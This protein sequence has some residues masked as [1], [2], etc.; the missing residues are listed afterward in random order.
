MKLE[1]MFFEYE[2]ICATGEKFT[3]SRNIKISSESDK[4][5]CEYAK[6]VVSQL[7]ENGKAITLNLILSIPDRIKSKLGSIYS[8][9]PESY[10]V[11]ITKDSINLYSSTERGLI[12][13]VST[14]KHL[15]E[16]GE[17]QEMLLYDYPDKEVR[18]YRVYTPGRKSFDAFKKVI[19]MLVEYKYNAVMLEV[20]GAMEYKRH[21]EINKKWEAFCSEVNKSPYEA[22]RIQKKTYPGWQKNSIHADNGGG[23]YITQDEMR[24]LIAYCR[25]REL[26]VIP[27]VP[28]LSH[29][30]YIVMTYPE[31]NE[32]AEDKYP[33][34]YCPSNP[35]SYEIV[36]DILDEV[37][38]VFNPQYVNIG[39]DECYTLAKCPKCRDKDP[40]DLY[41]GDIV[42]INDYLKA[43]GIKTI[44]WSEKFIDNV[45]LP[46][47]DGTLHGYGGTGDEAWDVPRCIGC[48]GKVPKD[49]TLLQWYWA[50]TD[51]SREKEICDMGY[52]M[53][54]GNFNGVLLKNYRERMGRVKGGF[55]SNWGAFE[56][57][58]M[59][60]NGQNYAL[61]ATSYVFWNR[62]YDTPQSKE[63]VGKVKEELYKRYLAALGSDKIEL[64]HTTDYFR[65]Y[66]SF[67]DGFYFVEDEWK[68]GEHVIEYTDG[69]E[70]HLPIIYGYNI[71]SEN[72]KE[73]LDSNST[74]AVTTAYVEVL[75]A[76]YP[77]MLDGKMFYR[78]AYENP[79]PEKKVQR[80]RTVIRDGIKIET[81]CNI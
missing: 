50:L 5:A 47:P 72:E 63:L 3:I 69:T 25:E 54:Y 67:Y 14:L 79:Y 22:E 53:I 76:T 20:G 80:M 35:K 49:V 62:D 73:V 4:Y 24:E 2:Y 28:T 78:T 56:G 38:D 60:R 42:K 15:Y 81:R 51:S 18:G 12:Y 32:R 61:L 41:V 10:A 36:F 66:R 48:V 37:I 77:T 68:I 74:E 19:D 40:V 13:A 29:S 33:D 44:M 57:M 43:R 23:S 9:N 17:I 30:D 52:N 70:V 58:Y 31:L 46:E 27:E 34:T 7:D 45:Y 59:Q 21:P 55:V 16:R 75:G 6:K 8:N 39:H 1:N 26:T 64:L 71:R 11:E 65:A